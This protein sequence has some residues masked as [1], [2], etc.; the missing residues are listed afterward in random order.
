ME[1]IEIANY[2]ASAEWMVIVF[3][4]CLF[5]LSWVK[6]AY[7]KRFYRL[8]RS[9]FNN[10]SLFQVMREELVFS[11]RGSIVL[12]F[13]FI[14]IAG[15]FLTLGGIVFNYS[16]VDQNENSLIQFGYWCLVI[17][18]IYLLKWVFN[19]LFL[20][21]IQQS[22]Y[23]KT[24]MFVVSTFNKIIGLVLLPIA[25]SAAYLPLKY[26]AILINIGVVLW[27]LILV[28]RLIKEVSIS[29]SYKIPHLYIILYLCAFEISPFLVGVKLVSILNI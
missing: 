5:L 27:A 22:D 6:N 14:L 24:F 3:L 11:H 1:V 21:L 29:I 2:N 23:L 15:L 8:L 13:I 4:T 12:T 17:I 26:A 28:Y 18:S 7:P 16:I 20:S 19:G 25:I 10:N 9:M